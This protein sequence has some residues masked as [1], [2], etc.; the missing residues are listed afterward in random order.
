MLDTKN[1]DWD[2]IVSSFILEGKDPRKEKRDPSE[3]WS[4]EK[5]KAYFLH[6]KKLAPLL[7]EGSNKVLSAYYQRQRSTDS[8]DAAR[9]TVRLLQSC[10]RLA[11]GHA[12][13]MCHD[14]VEVENAV[15]A[16]LLLECSTS[17]SASLV[18]GG[19]AL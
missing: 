10:I 7:G 9:T 19:N 2:K 13:L 4:F 6:I 11:Q 16:V 1:G 14:E 18:K 12:R 17:S 15:C 8:A 3:V 5:I